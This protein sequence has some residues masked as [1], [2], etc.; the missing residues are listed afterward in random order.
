MD[1]DLNYV[2]II[3]ILL[4]LALFI[5]YASFYSSQMHTISHEERK[6]K[7]PNIDLNKIQL[8]IQTIEANVFK[9]KKKFHFAYSIIVVLNFFG[10]VMGHKSTDLDFYYW[11]AISGVAYLFYMFINYLK[12]HGTIDPN[13]RYIRTNFFRRY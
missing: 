9:K 4:H 12:G 8:R 13:K 6:R 7:V 2:A 10:I 5:V 1:K 3:F 11:I